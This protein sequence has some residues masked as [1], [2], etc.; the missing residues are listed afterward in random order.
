[1]SLSSLFFF[2]LNFNYFPYS[3]FSHLVAI[4]LIFEFF[5]DRIYHISMC[6]LKLVVWPSYVIMWVKSWSV[7]YWRP[8]L[9]LTLV[10]NQPF[11]SNGTMGFCLF[12]RVQL[13]WNYCECEFFPLHKILLMFSLWKWISFLLFG[14]NFSFLHYHLFSQFVYFCVRI[15]MLLIQ[16]L[17]D[18][19]GQ[20]KMI[21]IHRGNKG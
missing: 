2:L 11:P 21:W 7:E 8:Y 18:S 13:H 16:I 9:C 3:P 4:P 20:R 19:S 15:L 1:L 6:F 14:T 5:Y 10:W 12:M 17:Q